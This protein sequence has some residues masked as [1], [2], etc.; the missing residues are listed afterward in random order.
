MTVYKQEVD[1]YKLIKSECDIIFDVGC[2]D[3]IDY[4]INSYD[5][6][7][8][9]HLFDPNPIFLK[10]IQN[11]I[12]KLEDTNKVNHL[13][14]LNPLGLGEAEGDMI[15]YPDAQSFIFRTI[16]T[17]CA[18]SSISFPLTTIQKY[19]CKN[20]ITNIDFLKIDIEGMEID[21]LRGGEEII[22]ST[23]KYIQFEFASTMLDRGI[24]PELLVNFFQTNFDLFLLQVDPPHPYYSQNKKL[25]TLLSEKIYNIVKNNMYEGFGCNFVAVRKNLSEKYK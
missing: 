17:T 14:Y 2:R 3:D 9:F 11:K 22:N 18:P 10:N 16:H 6:S 8:H 7:R 12:N 23:C 5:F 21:C 1:F 20:S 13:I 25:L 24:D 15:Y 19:C 4:L